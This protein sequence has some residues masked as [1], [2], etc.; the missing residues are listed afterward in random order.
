[1]RCYGIFF[2][3][4]DNRSYDVFQAR[5]DC[6]LWLGRVSRNGFCSGWIFHPYI[7]KN[8]SCIGSTRIKAIRSSMHDII[9]QC[10]V[11]NVPIFNRCDCLFSGKEPDKNKNENN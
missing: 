7:F 6:N 5:S 2:K 10:P 4:Y 11:R 8:E 3:C 1:M 9:V